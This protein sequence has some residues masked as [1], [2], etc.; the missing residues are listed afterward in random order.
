MFLY[1]NKGNGAYQK[2]QKS[3]ML[4]LRISL[5]YQQPKRIR[6]TALREKGRAK[7]ARDKT[8]NGK[9]LLLPC[10][11]SQLKSPKGSPAA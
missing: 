6:A 2:S 10:N 1:K 5:F 3:D 4:K 8:P 7:R 11:N 9:H